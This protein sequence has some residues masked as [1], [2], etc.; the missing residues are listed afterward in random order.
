M[1]YNA[2]VSAMPYFSKSANC[3]V[4]FGRIMLPPAA[5]QPTQV[6]AKMAGGSLGAAARAS[7]GD[8]ER[9]RERERRVVA[10]R[11]VA[12]CRN[13]NWG[14]IGGRWWWVGRACEWRDMVV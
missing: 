14:M 9:E 12:V 13:W 11:V 8:E 4:A 1:S 3:R 10:A 6:V 7:G 2:A 5:W